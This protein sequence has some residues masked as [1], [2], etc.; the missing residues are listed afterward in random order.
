[1][2]DL[3]KR[4]MRRFHRFLANPKIDYPRY[5]GRGFEVAGFVWFQ[6]ENDSLAQV[7]PNDPSTGFWNYYEDNLRD[8]IKDVARNWPC[9]SCPC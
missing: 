8:L 1:M 2:G 9:P 7:D 6:G 3:Y 4:M 5:D